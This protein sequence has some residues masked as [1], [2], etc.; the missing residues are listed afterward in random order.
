MRTEW[1]MTNRRQGHLQ[2]VR[3]LQHRLRRVQ[4]QNILYAGA[5]P[6]QPPQHILACEGTDLML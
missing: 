3:A 1:N 5:P 6:S 2:L 4:Q